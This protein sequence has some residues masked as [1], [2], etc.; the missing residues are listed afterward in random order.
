MESKTVINRSQEDPEGVLLHKLTGLAKQIARGNYEEARKLFEL[1]ITSS[2]PRAIA[3]LAE[4]LGM[5]IVKIE[6]REFKLGQLID[7]LEGSCKELSAAKKKLE[8][9]NQ[10]LERQ[11]FNRTEQLH[12]KNNELHEVLKKLKKE[13]KERK[14]A[15]KNLKQLYQQIEVTNQKLQDAYL[16]MRQKKDKL[17]ARKYQESVIF[18]TTDEGRICGFTEQAR[19]ITN[20][21]SA[22]LQGGH[23]QDFLLPPEGKEFLDLFRQVRPRMSNL[24]TLRLKDQPEEGPVYEAKLTHIGIEHKRL[25]YIVLYPYTGS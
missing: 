1:T 18:L 7:E 19:A 16:W 8:S 9:F 22:D 14:V 24:T 2:Y 21:N 6:S 20:K 23:I 12:E 17:E 25:F 13:N 10:T 5:M 3:E 15:E 4:S 11:V